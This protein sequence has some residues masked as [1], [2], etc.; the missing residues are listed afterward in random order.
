MF[1]LGLGLG[2][3]S[4]RRAS[5]PDDSLAES[6]NATPASGSAAAGTKP[7]LELAE[8]SVERAGPTVTVSPKAATEPG[9]SATGQ[10]K[11]VLDEKPTI[12]T[13]SRRYSAALTLVAFALAVGV[14]TTAMLAAREAGID[15]QQSSGRAVKPLSSAAASPTIPLLDLSTLPFPQAGY[16]KIPRVRVRSGPSLTSDEVTFIDQ[17]R[18]DYRPMPVFAVAIERDADQQLWY[19]ISV[20]G[21]PNGRYGWVLGSQLELGAVTQRIV[22]DR[23][24]RRLRY[25]EGDRLLLDTDVA[26]GKEGAETPLGRFYVI[27]KY[28]ALAPMRLRLVPTPSSLTGRAA[29]SSASTALRSRS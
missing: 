14:A 11:R 22:I 2:P 26:V 29:V 21:R 17:F 15:G 13:R 18:G 4:S 20:P 25:Y 1:L 8:S 10:P 19:K 27:A 28:K 3:W 24:E 7:K 23:S 5:T 6:G 16:L 9:Q 12:K